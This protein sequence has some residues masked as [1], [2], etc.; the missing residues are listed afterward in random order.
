MEDG[1]RGSDVYNMPMAAPAPLLR[2]S[3]S[4]ALVS[5]FGLITFV[6]QYVLRGLDDNRLTS[7]QWAFQRADPVHLFLVLAAGI[8]G[9]VLLV[10]AAARLRPSPVILFL[11]CF[12]AG[13]AFWPEPEVIVDASRYFTQAKHLELYGVRRFIEAWGKDIGV[14][15]DLPLVPFIYGLAFRIF[16][17]TRFCIQMCTTF[18]FSAGAVLTALIGKE[19]WDEETGFIGGMLLL[20]MPYLFTQAPLMLVD[21]PAMFFLLA[22]VYFFIRALRSGGWMT[23]A[24]AIS[25][26]TAFYAKYSNWLMLSI[27]AV[28][29]L[30]ELARVRQS[31]ED[32]LRCIRTF[33]AVAVLSGV[34]IGSVFLYKLDVFSG[35]LRFLMEYQKPGL[36]RWG[37]SFLS[38]FFFQI[39]PLVTAAA[40]FSLYV[41]ARKRD[42]SYLIVLWLILVVFVLQ[43]RRIRYV[44]MVLPMVGLMAAYGLA[45]LKESAVRRFYVLCA[46]ISSLVVALGAFLPFLE[47]MSAVN[48]KDAGAYLDTMR[49]RTVKVYVLP[50]EDPALNPAVSV[51]LLDL[52]TRKRIVY[53]Y[54]PRDFQQPLEKIEKSPLRFT[55]EYRNPDYYQDN[56]AENDAVVVVVSESGGDPLPQNISRII[57][58]YSLVKVCDA[59]EDVFQYRTSVRIYRKK[60][61]PGLERLF[62]IVK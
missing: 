20:G 7:W 52:F 43:I 2:K 44:I 34:M 57:A 36:R 61:A 37:E 16:G 54:D 31:P 10:S 29:L 24:A 17:E 1:F 21:V 41:A 45:G 46:V 47:A 42:V 40:V 22:A 3:D 8:A 56:A 33:I 12:L 58:G 38:T 59:H 35:Q 62:P 32:R 60:G 26:L 48:L 5:L 14:W 51:P 6:V 39:H 55:W 4:I 9:S 30:V 18:F 13:S 11:I 19:L 49:E 25:I 28:V 23:V 27:L 50:P 15:T 53:S